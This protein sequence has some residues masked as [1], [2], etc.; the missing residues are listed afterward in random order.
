MVALAS[1][2]AL[3][4]SIPAQGGHVGAIVPRI[5]ITE[6]RPGQALQGTVRI[7]GS[8]NLRN[9]QHSDL[10]FSYK[11]NSTDT[12]FSLAESDTG[13]VNDL[14]AV[15]DT[16]VITD[17]IYQLRLTVTTKDNQKHVYM[18][19]GLRVRNYSPIET[20]TPEPKQDDDEIEGIQVT[21]EPTKPLNTPTPFPTNPLTLQQSD[22]T[23]SA[24]R[25]VGAVVLIFLIG[26][27]IAVLRK[28]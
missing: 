21:L 15:W 7:I 6:P 4:S 1:A 8:T 9:F 16:T 5:E 2:L 22:L 23:E 26:T 10:S 20:N 12:W 28:A 14:L 18:V 17:N 13:V 19:E 24:L 11:V 3:V 25:G 27:G